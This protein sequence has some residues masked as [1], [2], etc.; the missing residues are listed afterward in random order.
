VPRHF[1]ACEWYY[2]AHHLADDAFRIYVPGVRDFLRNHHELTGR[3]ND[4]LVAFDVWVVTRPIALPGAAPA[5]AQRQKI[6]SYGNL[7]D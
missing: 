3:P 4:A 1:N 5:P 7:K 6:V 2:F